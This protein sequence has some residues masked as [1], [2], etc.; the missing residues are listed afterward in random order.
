[1]SNCSECGKNLALVGR[2]HRCVKP[3]YGMAGKTKVTFASTAGGIVEIRQPIVND[4]PE[5]AA[6]IM[7]ALS[8]SDLTSLDSKPCETNKPGFDKRAYQRELMRKR[9]A[10]DHGTP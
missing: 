9:R 7:E 3:A 6:A 4:K 2:V 8:N 1:M 5:H 10:K